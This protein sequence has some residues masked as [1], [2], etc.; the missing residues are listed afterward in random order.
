MIKGKV[1][2]V[3]IAL[4]SGYSI[5]VVSPS[6]IGFIP[7]L[8]SD[9]ISLYADMELLCRILPYGVVYD[10]LVG[11]FCFVAYLHNHIK[12]LLENKE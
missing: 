11:F 1:Q 8:N 10:V 9:E 4:K 5:F 6:A 3:N 7:L 2:L 12:G